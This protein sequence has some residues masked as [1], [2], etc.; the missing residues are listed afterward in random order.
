M[1]TS[2]RSKVPAANRIN[3]N[4]GKL[5]SLGLSKYST[6]DFYD[7]TRNPFMIQQTTEKILVMKE[8]ENEFND[9]NKHQKDFKK[10]YEKTTSTRMDRT[11]A[12]SNVDKI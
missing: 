11:G 5:P 6:N 2:K 8:L 12:I 4:I 9:L 10:V 7:D 1:Q 3:Y